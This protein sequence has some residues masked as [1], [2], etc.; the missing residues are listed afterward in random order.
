M[1]QRVFSL[2]WTNIVTDVEERRWH[3]AFTDR[4]GCR[5]E[6]DFPTFRAAVRFALHVALGGSRWDVVA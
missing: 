1:K 4:C 5:E 6:E 3:V 2:V